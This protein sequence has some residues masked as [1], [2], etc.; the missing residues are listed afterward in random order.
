[1]SFAIVTWNKPNVHFIG[2]L[3]LL[4]GT[5]EATKEQVESMKSHWICKRQIEDGDLVIEVKK[6]EEQGLGG[7]DSPK[8]VA[9]VSNTVDVGLLNQWALS[10]KRKAVAKAIAD[11]LAK[12]QAAPES[13]PQVVEGEKE[14]HFS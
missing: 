2:D 11:Q 8:A 6:E 5:N 1:M 9:L 4:P 12:I 14:E 7:F 3:R 10:E 13:K